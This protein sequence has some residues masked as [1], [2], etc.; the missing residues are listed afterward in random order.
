MLGFVP[1]LYKEDAAAWSG[2]SARIEKPTLPRRLDACDEAH[3]FP[4][5]HLMNSQWLY[6]FVP[7]SFWACAGVT[8]LLVQITLLAVTLYLHRDATHRSVDLHPAVRH[9]FRCWI[10]MSSGI[11][12]R[13]WVAVHRKHHA[14]ADR[15]GDPHSPVNEGLRRILLEGA[16]FYAV[17][18]RTPEVCE[19]YGKG[20][21]DDWMERNVYARHRYAGIAVL[22]VVELALFGVPAITM[23]GLHMLTMPVLAAGVINGL[24]HSV[25]YRNFEVDNAATNIIGWG[26]LVG[27]EE[28][29]NNHHAFPSS[30]KFSVRPWEFDSGW[31]WI[32]MLRALGLAKV[33]RLAPQPHIL[34]SGE[35]TD[36]DA[37]YAVISN[38]MHVLREYALHVITPVLGQELSPAA[39]DEWG[40]VARRLLTSTLSQLDAAGRSRLAG[41]LQDHPALKTAYEYQAQLRQLWD[42]AN[43]TQTA[44]TTTFIS[45][46][47]QAEA[48]GIKVLEEFA[49]RL[50]RFS[51]P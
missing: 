50:R 47:T 43:P 13:E 17:A 48:S 29:H 28:L 5:R 24:G 41:L 25:G 8:W 36:P 34:N 37:V 33:K 26:L 23:V 22:V 51:L 32:V 46:C 9:F 20:V 35:A 40:R 4:G 3:E 7:L 16:E 30:A 15:P 14:F 12:T 2:N 49:G 11:V 6:G 27:G 38:R 1:G 31:A 39:S 18:S 19:Y 10:W 44:L 42:M 45:W 21:P